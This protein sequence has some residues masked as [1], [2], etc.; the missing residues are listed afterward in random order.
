MNAPQREQ[1]DFGYGFRMGERSLSS[2]F[3]HRMKERYN[4]EIDEARV[5]VA[6][7]RSRAD[8]PGGIACAVPPQVRRPAG[9]GW[10]AGAGPTML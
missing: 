10:G 9:K 6:I 4:W 8:M 5:R 3:V 1:T 2:A 7:G